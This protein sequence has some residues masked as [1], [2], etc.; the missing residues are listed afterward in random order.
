MSCASMSSSYDSMRSESRISTFSECSSLQLTIHGDIHEET[1]TPINH[2]NKETQTDVREILQR[3]SIKETRNDTVMKKS[4]FRSKGIQHN[5]I[6]W[7][8]KDAACSPCCKVRPFS[9]A[10]SPTPVKF[11]TSTPYIKRGMAEDESSNCNEGRKKKCAR[12]L[13]SEEA[14][15]TKGQIFSCESSGPIDISSSWYQSSFTSINASVLTSPT[16]FVHCTTE[17]Q[18][19]SRGRT[20]KLMESDPRTYLGVDRDWVSVL[21][22]VSSKFKL[23][24]WPSGD[25]IHRAMPIGFRKSFKNVI[26]VGDCLEIS[27]QK[28]VDAF[29]QALTWSDYKKCNTIKY[30]VVITT[31]YSCTVHQDIAVGQRMK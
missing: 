3:F 14:T 19:K 16:S 10:H 27:I 1:E 2:I 31:A 26:G 11:V 21:A 24:V 8:L 4:H 13:F 18:R 6:T 7:S 5:L 22:L 12:S 30:Y 23:I 25:A 28:P 15:S 17:F 20:I 9:M 29:E